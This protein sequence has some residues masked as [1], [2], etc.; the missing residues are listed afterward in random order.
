MLLTETI[1]TLH[2]KP[3]T[4]AAI[5]VTPREQ[6]ILNLVAE[7]HTSKLMAKQLSLSVRT[8][9]RHRANLLK[10]FSQRNS[11]TLVQ[12]AIRHGLLCDLAD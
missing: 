4:A 6:Q 1:H 9:E 11:V 10:K 7:G 8:V 12:S 5:K 3:Q 2:L